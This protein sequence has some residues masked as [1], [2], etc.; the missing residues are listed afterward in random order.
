MIG[1]MDYVLFVSNVVPIKSSFFM[2][3]NK[4]RANLVR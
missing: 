1:F 2:V 3:E 4:T